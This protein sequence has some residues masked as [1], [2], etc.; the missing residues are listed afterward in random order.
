M[1]RLGIGDSFLLTFRPNK[2]KERHILIDCGAHH[3]I[4]EHNGTRDVA[5]NILL[6]LANS[7]QSLDALVITHE[8]WDH[9]SGFTEAR[10]LFDQ[11]TIREGWFAWTED[12]TDPAAKALKQILGKRDKAITC[13]IQRLIAA[14]SKDLREMG[15][16]LSAVHSFNSTRIS[17]G[18]DANK[19]NP[20]AAFAYAKQHANNILYFHPG[21]VH[22][23]EWL[24]GFRV[25]SLGPPK[26][27]A[28]VKK[29]EGA[30]GSQ[31]YELEGKAQGFF[32]AL[33]VSSKSGSGAPFDDALFWEDITKQD[34]SKFAEK[35]PRLSDNYIKERWR[36]IDDEWLTSGLR[37][38]LE[39]NDDTNNTSLALVFEHI[40][41]GRTLLFPGDAQI[42]AWLSWRDLSWTIKDE[43]GAEKTVT[44][45][46]LLRRAVFYKAGHHGSH[47]ATLMQGGLESMT[48]PDLVVAIP[49]DETKAKRKR[50]PWRMPAEKLHQRLL[51][52]TR[53]KILRSDKDAPALKSIVPPY[54]LSPR[55]W[56]LFLGC[57]RHDPN[58]LFIDYY[59]T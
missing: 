18:R 41:S 22:E 27:L 25:Y 39:Y 24:P 35:W 38:A 13:S 17:T 55:Q 4:Q 37:I 44:T 28:M 51:E 15:K 59:L 31:M 53:G 57:V 3:K 40:E 1:Y 47:N 12:Q 36:R 2:N 8:H 16:D 11:I 48:N 26:D 54:G 52:R 50:P 19:R 42:G 29:G 34:T 58:K 5:D 33:G 14:S 32:Q 23:P 20:R 43:Q 6:T 9:V 45:Q 30:V 10:D 46:D 49:V 21:T 56:S 7:N